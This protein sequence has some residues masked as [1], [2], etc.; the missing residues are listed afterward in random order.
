MKLVRYGAVGQEK[1][2]L[3][4]R[5][6]RIRDLSAQMKDIAGEA[7]SP[8]GLAK[9]AASDP[10]SAPKAEPIQK[11]SHTAAMAPKSDGRR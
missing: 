2:G 7:L 4:D 5:S 1:P 8:A 9:I 10:A 3:L 11:V 6:G